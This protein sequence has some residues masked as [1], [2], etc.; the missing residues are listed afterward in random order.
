[1]CVGHPDFLAAAAAAA[2]DETVNT[3]RTRPHS[4]ISKSIIDVYVRSLRRHRD[5]RRRVPTNIL[6]V[7]PETNKNRV[8]TTPS[9]FTAPVLFYYI[10]SLRFSRRRRQSETTRSPVSGGGVGGLENRTRKSFFSKSTV[11]RSKT[12]RTRLESRGAK[13]SGH[14]DREVF[15]AS[16]VFN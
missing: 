10:V 7:F 6:Y 9:S 5:A 4:S 8:H 2:A 12:S 13:N 15:T 3:I 11:T 16:F 1:M 14:R